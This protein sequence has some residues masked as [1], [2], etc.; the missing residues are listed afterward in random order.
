MDTCW[1][2]QEKPAHPDA[3][4]RVT[5]SRDVGRDVDGI[6]MVLI[7]TTTYYQTREVEIPR[8]R[9]CQS[10]HAQSSDLFNFLVGTIAV[11]SG[12]GAGLGIGALLHI[13]WIAVILG[14]MVGIAMATVF[15]SQYYRRKPHL[16]KV[17]NIGHLIYH[18]SVKSLKAQGWKIP[19][20]PRS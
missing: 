14:I 9:D 2:C 8:C 6:P 7:S 1:Y 19:E 11:G 20:F 17:K 15:V 13:T 16:K 18:P 10:A 4:V 3:S 12:L 5:L